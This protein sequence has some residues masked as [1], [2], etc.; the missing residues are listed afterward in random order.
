M[1]IFASRYFPKPFHGAAFLHD[2][3]CAGKGGCLSAGWMEEGALEND[4]NVRVHR[5]QDLLCSFFLLCTH[6]IA[7]SDY[8]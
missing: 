2:S 5:G 3:D 7:V 1:N 6:A 8:S 4:R